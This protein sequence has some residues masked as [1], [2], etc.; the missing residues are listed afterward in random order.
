M[1]VECCTGKLNTVCVSFSS[2]LGDKDVVTAIMIHRGTHIPP[3]YS[4]GCPCASHR[5]LFMDGDLCARRGERGGVVVELP[6][7]LCI[8]GKF[9]VHAGLS[10][11][12]ER[13]DGVWDKLAP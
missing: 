4:M 12:V 13:E 10:E 8:P 1:V 6:I 5:W 11:Q 7:Q 2:F 3:F 9:G